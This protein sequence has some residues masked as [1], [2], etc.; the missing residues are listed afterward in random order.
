MQHLLSDFLSRA[1]A[2]LV[3]FGFCLA[4]AF[5]IYNEKRL[6]LENDQL[7]ASGI[8]AVATVTSIDIESTG[9]D[10]FETFFDITFTF[11]DQAGVVWSGQTQP[12]TDSET[13]FETPTPG[14]RILDADIAQGDQILVTYLPDDPG[15]NRTIEECTACADLGSF[16]DNIGTYMGYF[17]VL[18]GAGFLYLIFRRGFAPAP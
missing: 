1:I 8:E 4:G 12:F 3:A 15:I 10:H 5:L 11:A 2:I 9:S 6:G 16:G 13:W 14:E 18:L 7:A 17:F